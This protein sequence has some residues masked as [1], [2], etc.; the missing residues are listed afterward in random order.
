[1]K[2]NREK[3]LLLTC[4]QMTR[5]CILQNKRW[6]RKTHM[7]REKLERDEMKTNERK[8]IIAVYVD[9][10]R[11]CNLDKKTDVEEEEEKIRA[12]CKFKRIL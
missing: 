9:E 3:N 12:S 6:R 2:D 1:M 8:N 4:V 7:R 11:E 10:E 5:K